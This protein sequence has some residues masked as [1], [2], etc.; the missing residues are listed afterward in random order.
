MLWVYST[1]VDHGPWVLQNSNVAQHKIVNLLKTWDFFV[2]FFYDL[3]VLFLSMNF[4]DDR[5]LLQFPKVSPACGR[6][7]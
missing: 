4:V 2:I 5:V 1:C 3:S 7:L 6:V